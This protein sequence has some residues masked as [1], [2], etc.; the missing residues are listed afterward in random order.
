MQ[1]VGERPTDLITLRIAPFAT[2]GETTLEVPVDDDVV[3]VRY[4]A[5]GGGHRVTVGPSRAHFVVET[6][7]ADAP[8][9]AL[10]GSFSFPPSDLRHR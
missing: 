9:V 6:V 7:G 5:S 1:W 4:V 3:A 8:A 10:T 2:D